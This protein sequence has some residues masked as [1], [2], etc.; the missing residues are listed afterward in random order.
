[1][2]GV[3]VNC[4]AQNT[5]LAAL[6]FALPKAAKY[7]VTRDQFETATNSLAINFQADTNRLDKIITPPCVCGPGLWNLLKDSPCISTP[8]RIKTVCNVPA[9]NGKMQQLPAASFQDEKEAANF[10]AALA[11]LISKNGKL[12]FRLPTEDEF[13][14]FWAVI[15]FDEISEP[16]V[17][18][19]G[20]DCNLIVLFSKGKLFWLDEVK[21][22]Q[23][24][25]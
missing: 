8:P 12:K 7:T 20:S 17:V 9:A 15:P 5:N 3:S 14:M 6:S 21:K 23:T 11:A 25:D 10:R 18:A 2:I 19:E 1:M 13:K 22:M 24:K 4:N 16:L